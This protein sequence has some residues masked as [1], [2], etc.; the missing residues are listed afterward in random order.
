MGRVS[1]FVPSGLKKRIT[2]LSG[3]FSFDGGSDQDKLDG[4]S[5][6]AVGREE[7]A[8]PAPSSRFPVLLSENPETPTRE[9]VRP[10]LEYET[11][12]RRAFATGTGGIAEQANLVPVY[13][14]HEELFVIRDVDRKKGDEGKYLMP[15]H[16]KEREGA[17]S[18]AI[19]PSLDEYGMNF[20]AF[21]HGRLRRRPL[22][23]I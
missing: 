5:T 6:G 10:Y 7:A 11:S 21:T 22:L 20:D 18:L 19:A 15:L 4:S 13:G 17:G 1:S 8:L 14:G 16:D 2:N 12:L 23:P 3:R 9:L